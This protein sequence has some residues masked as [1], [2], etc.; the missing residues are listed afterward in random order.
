MTQDLMSV[1]ERE[2]ER[3]RDESVPSSNN[4]TN[5]YIP[6]IEL[7]TIV[8]VIRKTIIIFILQRALTCVC[9]YVCVRVCMCVCV[10]VCVY[11]CVY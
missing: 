3:E 10:C 2:R 4:I 5:A 8:L 1:F 6:Y 11:A 7:N 9:V